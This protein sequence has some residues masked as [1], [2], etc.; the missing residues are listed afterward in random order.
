MKGRNPAT[1]IDT[2][3]IISGDE[4]DDVGIFPFVCDRLPARWLAHITS[5]GDQ[6]NQSVY[7]THEHRQLRNI[8]RNPPR[9]VFGERMIHSDA[10]CYGGIRKQNAEYRKRKR[11]AELRL[12]DVGDRISMRG[13]DDAGGCSALMSAIPTVIAVAIG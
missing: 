1:Q 8:Q 5:P 10:D 7:L 12:A 9:L 11:E 13:G 2:Q 6:D 4:L 3:L